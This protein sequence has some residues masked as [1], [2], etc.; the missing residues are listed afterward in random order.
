MFLYTN[1]KQNITWELITG[2]G[3]MSKGILHLSL[4]CSVLNV[5]PA[6]QVY[7][8]EHQQWLVDLLR[9]PLEEQLCTD[10]IA[11]LGFICAYLRKLMDA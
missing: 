5:S 8:L 11:A 2:S 6:G 4:D 7:R 10:C 9:L 3:L 1:K